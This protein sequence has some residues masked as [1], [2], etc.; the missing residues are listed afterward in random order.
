M[1]LKGDMK[2]EFGTIISKDKKKETVTVQMTEEAGMEIITISMD[3][4]CLYK[5]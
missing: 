4:V 5:I 3:D 1:V 2:G